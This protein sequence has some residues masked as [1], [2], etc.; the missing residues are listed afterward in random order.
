MNTRQTVAGPSDAAVLERAVQQGMVEPDRARAALEQ[1]GDAGRALRALVDGGRLDDGRL[2]E[3]RR[4]VE[5]AASQP[6]TIGPYAVRDTLGVGGMG[7][8]YRVV[9]DAGDEFAVKVLSPA[10][11]DDR[12]FRARFAAEARALLAVASPH[13]VAMRGVGEDDGCPYLVMELMRGGSAA[14]LADRSGGRL[15]PMLAARICRDAARGLEALGA[16]G[17]IHRDIKPE[18]IF[19]DAAGVAKLGDLGI[20]RTAI[21]GADRLT[22]AG[23]TVGTPAFMAPEQARAGNIDIRADIYALGATLYCLLVGRPAFTGSSPLMVM[24]QA[25]EKPL[26]DP[27]IL[28]PGCPEALRA[29]VLHAGAIDR[30]ARYADPRALREALDRVLDGGGGERLPAPAPAAV[31]AQPR[32]RR[33]LLVDDDQLVLRLHRAALMARG[34]AIDTA[35]SGEQALELVAKARF[36]AVLIDLVMDGIGGSEAIRRMRADQRLAGLRIIVLSNAYFEAE[37]REAREA[38]ADAILSKAA[39]APGQLAQAVERLVADDVAAASDQRAAVSTQ[40]ATPALDEA[41]ARCGHGLD[42]AVRAARIED[43]DPG[44]LAL[45]LRSASALAAGT[46]PYLAALLASLEALVRQLAAW[47]EHFNRPARRTLT[48]AREVLARPA[49]DDATFPAAHPAVIVDDD[50]VSR[51]VMRMSLR[52]VGFAVETFGDA[53]SAL[54]WLTG[55]AAS[56]VLSDVLMEEMNGIEFAA[57]ARKRDGQRGVPIILVTSLAGFDAIV[58]TGGAVDDVI[59]KPFLPLELGAKALTALATPHR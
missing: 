50:P 2:E 10:F 33:L 28:R 24:L 22:M 41:V 58:A 7:M 12:A 31:A 16:A 37:L 55:N 35:T 59:A 20:A 6:P 36:D 47:P 57:E 23:R 26:P 56:L 27:G 39:L 52:R 29:V 9:D 25:M 44:D 43:A 21:P 19:L 48:A 40:T 54:A 53:A 3:L 1:H 5:V 4:Q 49:Q 32:A 8:V 11:T 38:G 51:S 42:K 34:F 17:L 46:R 45:L 30:A 13:V 15:E 18:N 14:E